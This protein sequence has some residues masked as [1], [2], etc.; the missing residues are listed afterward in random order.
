MTFSFPLIVAF[1]VLCIPFKLSTLKLLWFWTFEFASL[2]L[3]DGNYGHCS[4]LSNM[5][6]IYRI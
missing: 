5:Q 3:F 6:S 1:D 2:C 4:N